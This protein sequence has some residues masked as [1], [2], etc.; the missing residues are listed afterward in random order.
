[1]LTVFDFFFVFCLN[2][3]GL[4]GFDQPISKSRSMESLL[5]VSAFGCDESCFD[6]SNN[7][8]HHI[9]CKHHS[10][11]RALSPVGRSSR[12]RFIAE[13]DEVRINP[14]VSKKGY[15]HFLDTRVTGWVKK[16]V[17]NKL[18]LNFFN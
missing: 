14:I 6:S 13:I 7:L 15:L 11:K 5:S 3:N 12:A 10:S 16:Y 4:L 17:V 8:S 9:N 2:R 18:V 1:M